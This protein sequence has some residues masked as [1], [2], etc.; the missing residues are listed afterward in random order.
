MEFTKHPKETLGK[1]LLNA[2]FN[3]QMSQSTHILQHFKCKH[4]W[5]TWYEVKL[6]IRSQVDYPIEC[7]IKWNLYF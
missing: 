7:K 5:H 6:E 1:V 3:G 4:R 2:M